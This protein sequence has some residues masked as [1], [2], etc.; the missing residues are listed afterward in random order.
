MWQKSRNPDTEATQSLSKKP[1]IQ[2]NHGARGN[3]DTC[4]VSGHKNGCTCHVQDD[5]QNTE[6]VGTSPTWENIGTK[7]HVKPLPRGK[8]EPEGFYYECVVCR[9]RHSKGRKLRT[10]ELPFCKDEHKDLFH[11]TKRMLRKE[12]T[13]LKERFD[14]GLLVTNFTKEYYQP[15]KEKRQLK[16]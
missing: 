7:F 5:F 1:E 15:K 4:S 16:Q 14:L 9:S 6:R 10:G 13:K 11:S 12:A 2:A 3:P 8:D